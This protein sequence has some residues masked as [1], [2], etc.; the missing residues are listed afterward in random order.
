MLDDVKS[1]QWPAGSRFVAAQTPDSLHPLSWRDLVARFAIARSLRQ[2]GVL[3]NDREMDHAGPGREPGLK[4]KRPVNLDDL[5][6]RK[7]N[8]GKAIEYGDIA[9]TGD[10]GRE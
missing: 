10:R 8:A 3:R 4:S 1:D 7:P 2:A 6:N 9:R 5:C